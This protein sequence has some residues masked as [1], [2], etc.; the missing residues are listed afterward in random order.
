MGPQRRPFAGA[1]RSG[2]FV[3]L[4]KAVRIEPCASGFNAAHARDGNSDF[5]R[6]TARFGQKKRAAL[7]P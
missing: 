1:K 6:E 5:S 4:R 2:S 7:P 3:A